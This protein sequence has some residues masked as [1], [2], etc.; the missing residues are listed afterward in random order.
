MKYNKLE[1]MSS[2]IEWILLFALLATPLMTLTDTWSHL[3]GGNDSLHDEL[4]KALGHNGDKVF[5]GV[6]DSGRSG[7][8]HLANPA[9]TCA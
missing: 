4:V 6:P 9:G 3:L 2:L 1:R 7:P 8:R 5:N